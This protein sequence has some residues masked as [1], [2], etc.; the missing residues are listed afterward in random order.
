MGRRRDKVMEQLGVGNESPSKEPSVVL[1]KC[2]RRLQLGG[3]CQRQHVLNATA[4][5]YS[6]SPWPFL[7]LK[8]FD[9]D[10]TEEAYL[11]YGGLTGQVRNFV[12]D[13]WK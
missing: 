7:A 5:A 10:V 1:I 3:Q 11:G 13:F 12:D 9:F 4:P 2:N 8:L 6:L